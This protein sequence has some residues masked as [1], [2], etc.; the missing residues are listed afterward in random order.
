[1]LQRKINDVCKNMQ[2]T[3]LEVVKQKMEM[4]RTIFVRDATKE[5]DEDLRDFFKF[6]EEENGEE[7]EEEEEQQDE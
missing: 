2:A 1:M 6:D 4:I 5:R 7:E 3:Y